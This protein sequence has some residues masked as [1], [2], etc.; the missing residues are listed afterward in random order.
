MLY[1]P[2]REPLSFS[3]LL[4]GGTRSSAMVTALFNIL[5]FRRAVLWISG[6]SSREREPAHTVSVAADAND[7]ITRPILLQ[8][9][10][11]VKRK[12]STPI[13]RARRDLQLARVY[14]LWPDRSGR[15]EL[16]Q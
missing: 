8:Y 1:C 11:N 14:V 2:A 3:N 5:S 13:G 10:T 7:L 12:Y 4:F 9:S 16:T 15:R 6:G